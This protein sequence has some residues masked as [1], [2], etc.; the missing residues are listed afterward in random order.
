VRFITFCL[1]GLSACFGI[2]TYQD[3]ILECDNGKCP[4]D[5]ECRADNRCYRIG[6]QPDAPLATVDAPPMDGPI[7]DAPISPFDAPPCT[8][9][10]HRCAAG[11]LEVCQAGVWT[12]AVPSCADQ[13]MQCFDP[14]PAGGTDAYCGTCLKGSQR[15]A[16]TERQTCPAGSGVWTDAEACTAFG[17]YDPDGPDGPQAYCGVCQNGDKR[18]NSGLQT[19]AQGQWGTAQN[20]AAINASWSCFDPAPTGGSD[21]YCGLC[22]KNAIVCNGDNRDQCSADGTAFN[23]LQMCTWGCMVSGCC[24]TPTCP[25]GTVC[26]FGPPNACGRSMDCG[27]CGGNPSK[28][29]EGTICC[30]VFSCCQIGGGCG[31]CS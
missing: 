16:S 10:E 5:M 11:N 23:N 2:P 1:L 26:G 4:P 17:C 25:G 20:C 15:C 28:C 31:P 8:T 30:N 9:G 22:L 7:I 19:C 29:C 12:A 27:D 6:A 3:G 14:A 24:S 13:S 21:A 18:C